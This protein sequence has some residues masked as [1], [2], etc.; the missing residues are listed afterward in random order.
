VTSSASRASALAR[1]LRAAIDGDERTITELCAE[2]LRV[3]TPARAASSRDEVVEGLGE[4]DDLL[5]YSEA[6]IRPLDVGGPYAAAEWSV[7]LRRGPD[8]VPEAANLRL[9]GAAVAEFRGE[10]ICALR[11]YWDEASV[12]EH[13]APPAGTS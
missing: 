3:W 8:E 2:D 9:H 5:S 6:E 11:L 12:F 4:R 1:V 10:D 7:T 13:L